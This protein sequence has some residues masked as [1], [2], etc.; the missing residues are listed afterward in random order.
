MN[1]IDRTQKPQPKGEISF[2]LPEIQKFRLENGLNVYFIKKNKFPILQ[3]NLLINGGSVFDPKDRYGLSNL[4]SM[5]IDEGAG[6][7]DSLQL[8]DEFDS[9]GTHF[10]VS[11]SEDNLYFSLQ[12]LEENFEKSLDLFSTVITKPHLEEKDF[13]RERRKIITRILQ[14]QDEPDEIADM[15]YQFRIYGKTNPYAF[16]VIGYENT[17][18]DISKDD[19][20][21]Y[22]DNYL[23]PDNSTLIIVGDITREKLE[24]KLNSYLRDWKPGKA[25]SNADSPYTAQRKKIYLADKKDS[26]QSEIR[27]GHLST[28]RNDADYFS[29]LLLNTIL[30]GQFTS[31]I[32]LNLRERKGYTYGAHSR[33]NYFK[34]SADFC[35]STSVGIENTANA[36]H[37]IFN[38][39]N[40]IQEG[41]KPEEL[42]FAKSSIIRKFPS[43][44][45]TNKQI[46][47]NIIGM[48]IHSLPDNYFNNYIE[49][50]K[51]IEMDNVNS[52]AEK[53][54]K[55]NESIIILVGDKAKLIEQFKNFDIETIETDIKGELKS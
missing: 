36:V 37:E 15:V 50:I 25:S 20:K 34:N 39:L 40:G 4:F 18:K 45:E 16:P 28:K 14:M 7:F 22:R 51:S 30:G 13:H 24:D 1:L 44:F 54:I 29:K 3:V 11:S 19:I 8:S 55:P 43:N 2:S 42:E 26:V 46:A 33:F 27:I 41:I 17:V 52:A 31:R 49:E 48:V 38:E 9:L 6:D 12:T 5:V 21:G 35:V 53:Y 10:S 32:N 47:S 23:H